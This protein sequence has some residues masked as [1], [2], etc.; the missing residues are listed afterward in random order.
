MIIKTQTENAHGYGLIRVIRDAGIHIKAG[1]IY[2]LLSRLGPK[3]TKLIEVHH[4]VDLAQLD[5]TQPPIVQRKIYTIT[6][7][8]ELMIDRMM[9]IYGKYNA[10]VDEL[11]QDIFRKKR[12]IK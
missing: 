3:G 2:P 4:H 5:P 6:P 11:Y 12:R 1:T 8:G 9:E 7:A 10:F